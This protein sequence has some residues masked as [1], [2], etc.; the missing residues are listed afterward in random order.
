MITD[1]LNLIRLAYPF[2]DLPSGIYGTVVISTNTSRPVLVPLSAGSSWLKSASG[3]TK[4]GVYSWKNN[5]L[6]PPLTPGA[7]ND[8]SAVK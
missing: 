8:L 3:P 7:V 5:S 1:L 4:L 6:G 2:K